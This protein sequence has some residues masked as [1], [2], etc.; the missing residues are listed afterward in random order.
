[1]RCPQRLANITSY[2][3]LAVS[4]GIEQDGQTPVSGQDQFIAP[5]WEQQT[6]PF[7]SPTLVS[8]LGRKGSGLL[9]CV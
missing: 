2:W 6:G 5:Y 9:P 8:R 3:G 7:L 1:M 4:V